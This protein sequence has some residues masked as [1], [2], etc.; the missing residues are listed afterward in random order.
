MTGPLIVARLSEHVFDEHLAYHLQTATPS[1]AAPDPT[2]CE[3]WCIRDVRGNAGILDGCPRCFMFGLVTSSDVVMSSCAF[4]VGSLKKCG[5]DSLG[6]TDFSEIRA[7][8]WSAMRCPAATVRDADYST[9]CQP[10]ATAIT[11]R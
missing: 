7:S 2:S 1:S 8:R 4:C 5:L 9:M 11:R 10:N 6:L 3:T